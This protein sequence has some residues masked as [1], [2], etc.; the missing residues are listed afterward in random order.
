MWIRRRSLMF[1][2]RQLE[3]APLPRTRDPLH[4]E[5]LADDYV[6]VKAY[7]SDCFPDTASTALSHRRSL[8]AW[9][10]RRR[11]SSSQRA[12]GSTIT[13]NSPG[14]AIRGS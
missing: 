11:W 1:V 4:L 14:R 7:F 5:G 13:G 2:H 12:C 9:P 6:V 8:R 3:F 10:S